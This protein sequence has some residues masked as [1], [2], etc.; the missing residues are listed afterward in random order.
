MRF[1][2][3]LL[4]S[5]L[6]YTT[7]HS[8]SQISGIRGKVSDTHGHPLAY[9][10]IHVK[11]TNQGTLA[12]SEGEYELF[13]DPGEYIIHYQHLGFKTEVRTLKVANDISIQN[14]TLTEQS[15]L[16]RELQVGKDYEDPAYTIMRKAI[17]KAKFHQLQVQSYSATVYARST[18]MPTKIPVL[19]KRRFKKQGISEGVAFVNESVSKV[20]FS[21]PNSYKQVIVSTQNN[22]DNSAPTP[23]E[24]IF[25]SFYNP[26]VGGTVTPL[27]P[28]ALNVYHFEYEGHFEDRGEI[29]NKI[30]V[31]PKSFK[32]GVFRGSI[33]IIEDRWSIHSFNLETLWQ[34]FQIRVKQLFAPID[35]VWVPSSQ[36][37]DIN[38]SYLGFAG[39]F[40][41]IVSIKYEDI[42]IDPS[43]KETVTLVDPYKES[44]TPVKLPPKVDLEKMIAEGKEVDTKQFRKIVKEYEK[45]QRKSSATGQSPREVRRDTIHIEPLA[46]QRDST[47]WAS[48]RSIPLTPNEVISY[49]V[50]DSL[51][52]SRPGN[53]LGDSTR[54]KPVHLLTGGRY[55]YAH[56]HSL[57]LYAPLRTLSFN[58]VEAFNFEL[59]VEWRKKWNDQQQ[60]ALIPNLHYATGRNRL[61]PRANLVYVWNN[62]RISLEGGEKI[63]QFN[64]QNPIHPMVNL[65]YYSLF[66]QNHLRLYQK[67]YLQIEFRQ[68][69]LADIMDWT[70]NLETGRRKWLE[71]LDK[72]GKFLWGN[73]E[74]EDNL[75]SPYYFDY[76]SFYHS[77]PSNYTVFSTTL[78]I[79]PWQRYLVRNGRKRL[80]S[81]N[82]PTFTITYKKGFSL[83]NSVVDYDLVEGGFR[84]EPKIGDASTLQ[85]S[86]L[87]GRFLNN[88]AMAFPDFKHF[89]GNQTILQT[90]DRLTGF[91][92]LPYYDYSTPRNY[93]VGHISYNSPKLLL[94]QIQLLRML[95]LKEYLQLHL[96]R[97]PNTQLYSEQVYGLDGVLKIFRLEAVTHFHQ[98]VYL[99]WGVRVGT[100][101]N[102]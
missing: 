102:F 56:G 57:T 36:H 38:G 19:M 40:T 87:A 16:L 91:R 44:S 8:Q 63:S 65:I 55:R 89:M 25:A 81:S 74:K 30:K 98:D 51:N 92:M 73:P 10:G 9:A 71:N 3:I 29:I 52:R 95:G 26:E 34:G 85:L 39:K 62:S 46:N 28:K 32:Q 97:T 64:D 22:L 7:V 4:V 69:Y 68:R 86:G 45:E 96:L 41:Y 54:F 13:L 83:F 50:S 66:N 88:K 67:N 1:Y 35:D 21:R 43:L 93:L 59:G 84:Y 17:A 79:R 24:F 47:Y 14:I 48:V 58:P 82:Q 100:I 78:E 2:F 70:V 33:Y 101:F 6:F 76:P 75:N 77:Y 72:G 5:F 27:S 20:D 94:S 37:F 42:K 18:A 11:G 31:T 60:F 53:D 23:N 12:N 80:L 15:L 61:S 49:Q 90:G 99:G